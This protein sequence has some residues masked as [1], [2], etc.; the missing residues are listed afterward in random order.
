MIDECEPSQQEGEGPAMDDHN[1]LCDPCDIPDLRHVGRDLPVV[2]HRD[3]PL[4]PIAGASR[5]NLFI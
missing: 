5:G 3:E 4:R 1:R 2:E